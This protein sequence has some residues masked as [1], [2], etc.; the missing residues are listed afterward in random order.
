LTHSLKQG[1]YQMGDGLCSLF[2]VL[3][4][5]RLLFPQLTRERDDGV[6]DGTERLRRQLATQV[7]GKENFLDAWLD[8]ADEDVIPRL[9]DETRLWLSEQGV[10]HVGWTKID[11][12]TFDAVREIFDTF[13]HHRVVLVGIGGAWDH[14][15]VV[16]HVSPNGVLVAFDSDVLRVIPPRSTDKP[17]EEA[18][19]LEK[20]G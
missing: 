18:Y 8:G 1:S 12:P 14:Y 13:G 11:P 15:T 16:T 5:A 7:I 6:E 9:L 4:A 20:I 19:V 17:I 2:A 3:N 10:G